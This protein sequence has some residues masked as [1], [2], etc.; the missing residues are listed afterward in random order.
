MGINKKNRARK[1]A[2]LKKARRKQIEK[3]RKRVI[4]KIP[5]NNRKSR[6]P[7]LDILKAVT[8]IRIPE[9]IDTQENISNITKDKV[10][11]GIQSL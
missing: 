1:K 10:M 7:G 6:L 3:N 9:I 2:E 11:N 5:I 8:S 4:T